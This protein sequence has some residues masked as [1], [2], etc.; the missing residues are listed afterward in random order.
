MAEALKESETRK[1]QDALNVLKTTG[2]LQ[3][4]P[5]ISDFGSKGEVDG[6]M[7]RLAQS[8]VELRKS[9]PAGDKLQTLR[10][11]IDAARGPAEE[12]TVNVVLKESIPKAFGLTSESI[13][14]Y[15]GA[16]A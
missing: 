3:V 14:K 9:D 2:F 12:A 5:S 8:Y 11:A 4:R 1:A 7:Q 13:N 6:F 10:K 15:L 16:L